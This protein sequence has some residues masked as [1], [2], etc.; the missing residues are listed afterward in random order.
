MKRFLIE[1]PFFLNQR[2]ILTTKKVSYYTVAHESKGIF[3]D[4]GS[5]FLSFVYPVKE[6]NEI[7][8]LMAAIKKEY[9]D[10]RHHCYAYR[11]GAEKLIFRSNDDGEPI[12]NSGPTHLR[13]DCIE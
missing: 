11:L 1:E 2:Q 13:P 10:A 7:R 6:E 5:K 9:F 8:E 3:K 4:K 12:R